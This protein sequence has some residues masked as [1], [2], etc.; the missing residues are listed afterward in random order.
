M[1]RAEFIAKW[2]PELDGLI[3]HAITLV[4]GEGFFGDGGKTERSYAR[5]GR[6]TVDQ[7]KAGRELL[8]RLY[9]DLQT[10]ETPNDQATTS[11]GSTLTPPARKP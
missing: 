11:N 3:L 7:L 4:H 9:D 5:L 1:T 10:K 6:F 2:R 8:E